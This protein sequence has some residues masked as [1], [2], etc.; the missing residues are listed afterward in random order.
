M[1]FFYH[2]Y[3]HRATHHLP[4]FQSFRSLPSPTARHEANDTWSCC[5]WWWW[6]RCKWVRIQLKRVTF[7]SYVDD[8]N[9]VDEL[10]SVLLCLSKELFRWNVFVLSS[11]LPESMSP[12]KLLASTLSKYRKLHNKNS[13]IYTDVYVYTKW[14]ILYKQLL[15]TVTDKLFALIFS[16]ENIIWF[17]IEKYT[18][19]FFS[20]F[21]YI[22]FLLSVFSS[23]SLWACCFPI[24]KLN[25]RFFVFPIEYFLLL[26]ASSSVLILAAAMWLWLENCITLNVLPTASPG[27]AFSQ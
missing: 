6:R 4:S 21:I 8:D 13:H 2:H 3:H 1:S 10:M 23:H 5:W 20:L 22:I 14:N 15:L 18:F 25:F 19:L 9:A 7:T 27:R 16:I 26:V 12:S 17:K 24:S 11:L